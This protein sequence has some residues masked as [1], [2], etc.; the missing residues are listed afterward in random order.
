LSTRTPDENLKVL[1]LGIARRVEDE[2]LVGTP[3]YM[4]PERIRSAKCKEGKREID[5]TSDL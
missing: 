2:D 3:A 4:S 5:G 1:G